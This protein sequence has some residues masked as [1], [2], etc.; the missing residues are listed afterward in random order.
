MSSD[1][2]DVTLDH[3][4]AQRIVPVIRTVDLQST[5]NHSTALVEAGF[6]SLEITMTNPSA[7]DAIREVRAEFPDVFVGAGTVLSGQIADQAV[8]AGAQFLVSPCLE[9]TVI[10]AGQRHRVPA[11]PGVATP[12]ELFS[13][14]RLGASVVKL[15]PAASIGRDW[16]RSVLALEPDVRIVATGGIDEDTLEPW[17][18]AGA[19]ACGIGG[20][21]VKGT[22]ATIRA[23]ARRL[24]DLAAAVEL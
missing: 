22:E 15:F 4:L 12:S 6:H 17:L 13:A 1:S 20:S 8:A 2:R 21:L 10:A 16:L 9:P 18:L 19:T 7:L 11:V 24:L 5:V 23:R 3:W 14:H